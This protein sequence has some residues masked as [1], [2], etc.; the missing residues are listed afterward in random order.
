MDV[1]P[2]IIDPAKLDRLAD[3]AVRVGLNVQPGQEVVVTAG[4]E[5]I[6]LLRRI[7][8]AAYRAGASHVTSLLSDDEMSLI[9]LQNAKDETLD[10][11]PGWLP[12]GMAKAFYAMPSTFAGS[13]SMVR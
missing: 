13:K 9:R 2:K 6:P 1:D 11:A 10:Y 5:A 7:A 3:V 4:V 12:E 8:V